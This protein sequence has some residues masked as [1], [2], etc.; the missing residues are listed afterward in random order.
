MT[1]LR[2]LN[3]NNTPVTN[4]ALAAFATS[5]TLE[6]LQVSAT[7]VTAPAVQQFSAQKPGVRVYYRGEK[8]TFTI[9]Y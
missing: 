9:D 4:N 8:I 6:S 3:L 2:F 7:G 5:T 1:S